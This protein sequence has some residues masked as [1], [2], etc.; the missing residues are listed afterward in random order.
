MGSS[1]REAMVVGVRREEIW[2]CEPWGSQVVIYWS[3]FQRFYIVVKEA[4]LD[5][6][7]GV[8]DGSIVPL[9]TCVIGLLIRRDVTC[10]VQLVRQTFDG[11]SGRMYYESYP[12]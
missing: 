10:Q 3:N 11:L 5:G 1:L 9:V 4:V 6:Q 12:T 7:E 2:C 8:R